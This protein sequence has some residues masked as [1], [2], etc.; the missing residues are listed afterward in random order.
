MNKIVKVFHRG[1]PHKDTQCSVIYQLFPLFEV[2]LA[3]NN[4]LAIHP[5][6]LLNETYQGVGYKVSMMDYAVSAFMLG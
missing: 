6:F 4:H 5:S 1:L 2:R 3:R